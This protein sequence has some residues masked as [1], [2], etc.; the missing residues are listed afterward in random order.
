MSRGA[1]RKVGR[2][3][4]IRLIVQIG[5]DLGLAEGMVAQGDH[6]RP[7]GEQRLRLIPGQTAAGDVLPVDHGEIYTLLPLESPELLL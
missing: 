7:S 3:Q 6:V 1:A 5:R 2:P 4:D